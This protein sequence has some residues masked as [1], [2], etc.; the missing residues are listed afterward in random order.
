M[1]PDPDDCPRTVR[2]TCPVP[3]EQL[4]LFDP[5]PRTETRSGVV[6]R[7]WVATSWGQHLGFWYRHT[8]AVFLGRRGL[9]P[10]LISLDT[11]VLIEFVDA[12][13]ELG[14]GRLLGPASYARTAKGDDRLMEIWNLV[15]LWYHR[16]VRFL[17][18]ETYLVDARI[19]LPLERR[20]VRERVIKELNFHTYGLRGGTEI[21]LGDD[22]PSWLRDVI[23]ADVVGCPVHDRYAPTQEVFEAPTESAPW[24]TGRRDRELLEEALQVKAHVF[25]TYD[26]GILRRARDF[27]PS[28][29]RSCTPH[30]CLR[31]LTRPAN[32]ITRK[33]RLSISTRSRE[34]GR[35][36]GQS[37]TSRLNSR[38]RRAKGYTLR[39]RRSGHVD[40]GHACRRTVIRHLRRRLGEREERCALDCTCL[41]CRVLAELP[42]VMARVPGSGCIASTKYR[43]ASSF[44]RWIGWRRSH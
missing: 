37:R 33:A 28:G 24:P 1:E 5:G 39:R 17:V 26:D 20:A 19:S 8:P 23:N 29:C 36:S 41:S 3:R 15:Q 34:S 21:I 16:D 2:C 44:M 25:L 38:D 32:S 42:P 35:S 9:G 13:V 30:R 6:P 27:A 40:Y 18:G 12:V 10:L 4:T 22:I 31:S 11:G 14:E 7:P 43:Q